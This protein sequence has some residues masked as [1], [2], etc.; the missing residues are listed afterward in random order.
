M[1]ISWSQVTVPGVEVNFTLEAI[2]LNTSASSIKHTLEQ[3]YVFAG[4]AISCDIYSFRV[5]A[6]NGAGYSNFSK[7]ATSNLPSIPDIAPVE[8]S[9]NYFLEETMEGVQLNVTI[10]VSI[11]CV[12]QKSKLATS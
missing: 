7:T 1:N 2:N 9:L 12:L 5:R 4:D 6:K 11:V 3:H 10:S 8:D